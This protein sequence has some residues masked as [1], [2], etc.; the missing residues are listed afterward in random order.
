MHHR[1]GV[2]LVAR[3]ACP[4]P[5]VTQDSKRT[6]EAPYVVVSCFEKYPTSRRV[7]AAAAP[8]AAP[9][10]VRHAVIVSGPDSTPPRSGLFT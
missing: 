7:V 5:D 6:C 9:R 10:E 4:P 1:Q 3:N 8:A 2:L